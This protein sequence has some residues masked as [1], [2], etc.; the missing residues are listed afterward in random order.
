MATDKLIRMA[1]QMADFFRNQP[2][3]PAPQA[4]AEHINQFWSYQ[5][6]RDFI[7]RI[8]AGADAD[9]IVRAA[10]DFIKLPQTSS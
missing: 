4:V 9:P 6:R 8:Q 2:D 7:S 10:A 3:V 5:M 1:T